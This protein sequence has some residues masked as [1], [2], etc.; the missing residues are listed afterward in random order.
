MIITDSRQATV[1]PGTPVYVT[2]EP[3]DS[4]WGQPSVSHYVFRME[5]NRL[6][7]EPIGGVCLPR[8]PVETIA[9]DSALTKE[10][11]VWDA[12]SDE[13][14]SRFEAGLD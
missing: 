3:Q 8:R 13:A 11:S 10:F 4:H 6:F 1:M 9:V 14:L 12:L 7:G 5:N 2:S